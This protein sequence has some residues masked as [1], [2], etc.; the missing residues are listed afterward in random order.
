MTAALHDVRE[1]DIQGDHHGCAC[2][3]MHNPS[4]LGSSELHISVIAPHRL[5]KYMSTACTWDVVRVG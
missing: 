4:V 5:R 2:V 3:L 1:G